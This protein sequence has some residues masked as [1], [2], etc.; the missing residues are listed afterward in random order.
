[1]VLVVDET[2]LT[3]EVEC[4]G[5][6][7][8]HNNRTHGHDEILTTNNSLLPFYLHLLFLSMIAGGIVVALVSVL[9]V[10]Q[11]LEQRFIAFP[12]AQ[13]GNGITLRLSSFST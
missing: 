1:M 7:Q 10:V 12:I 13:A 8:Q 9:P 11:Y 5:T 6:S 4:E 3:E 2:F